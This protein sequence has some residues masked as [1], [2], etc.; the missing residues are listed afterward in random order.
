MTILEQYK[1]GLKPLVVEEWFDLLIYRPL[2]FV[3]AWPLS[4]T[5][6]R[7][8]LVTFISALV[9]VLGGVAIY[10]GTYEWLVWGALLYM[11]SNILDCTDG[12]LA[13]MTKRFSRYGRI[14]DGV[15]DYVVGAAVFIAIV[16]SWQPEGYS[17][18]WW[19]MLVI[20]GGVVG[21]S[22]QGMHLNHVRQA[23]L[24][25][26]E[27]TDKKQGVVHRGK[28]KKKG[29][30]RNLF[31][32]PFFYL[33]K[34]YLNRERAVRRKVRLPL[35]LPPEIRKD[36]SL[37]FILILWTF[38]GKGTHVTVFS[39]FMLI[40]KPE[41]YM[42]FCLIPWNIWIFLVW[43]AHKRVLKKLNNKLES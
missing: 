7:P 4:K 34:L 26:I 32:V 12:Q 38:T 33:Y 6:V 28:K 25:A 15:A 36:F 40:G 23:Y 13:R 24:H 27:H 43:I 35:E 22:Y 29:F 37:R 2:G 20:F 8:N 1:K 16:L 42:W 31:Y 39:F 17:T 19:W 10:F 5:P 3:F 9:G 11:F 21:T 30:I 14:Y 41:Y 18:F